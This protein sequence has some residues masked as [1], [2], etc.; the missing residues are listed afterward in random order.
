LPRRARRDADVRDVRCMMPRSN[1]RPGIT[2]ENS[3]AALVTK[4]KLRPPV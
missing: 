1:T 3:S 2:V 4:S